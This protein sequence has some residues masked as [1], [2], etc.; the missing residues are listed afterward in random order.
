MKKPYLIYILFILFVLSFI[1]YYIINRPELYSP[2]EM[3]LIAF[4][5][6]GA[7]PVNAEIYFWGRVDDKKYR[8]IDEL[9][10]LAQLLSKELGINGGSNFSTEI[11]NND[12]I[13]E[14]IV[15]G[16]MDQNRVISLNIQ[17]N[18]VP[19]VNGERFVSATVIEDIDHI[20][21]ERTRKEVMQALKKF[22]I[23]AKVS[24]CIT[25]NFEGRMDKQQ[26]NDICRNVFEEVGAKKIEDIKD[27]N[28]ISV[29]AYS[30]SI[31]RFVEV[32]EN[33]INLNIALRYNSYEDKTYIWLATPV[34]TTEY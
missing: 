19:D 6:S 21:M 31:P 20:N 11:V 23:D 32:N 15:N 28:L 34:I 1:F 10:S 5:E 8:N 22:N 33:R 26:L 18:K 30:P 14:V 29:S 17:L 12:L 16:L 9:E 7:R 3:L 13:Q 2:E 25:G 24:S 4:N 27:G